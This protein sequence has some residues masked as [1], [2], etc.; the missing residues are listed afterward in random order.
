MNRKI[1]LVDDE[2]E[3]LDSFKRQ[4]RKL[5][6]IDT[7][8][9]GLNGLRRVLSSEPFAVIVSDYHMPGID[10]IQF[11]ASVKQKFPD[12]VRIMLTGKAELQTA[13]DAVN[14]GH[15][16]RF[17][18]KPCP[19][20]MLIQTLQAGLEQYRLITA[21][22]DLLE[23]TLS[24][25]IK[26]LTEILS[27][28]N[29]SAFGRAMR[30]KSYVVHMVDRLKIPEAWQYEIAALLSFIGCVT[31]PPDVMDK[32][33]TGARLSPVEADLAD[34]HPAVAKELLVN[35]PR[36]GS[37]ARMIEA[38]GDS[39]VRH[40]KNEDF[41]GEDLISLGGNL[42]AIAMDFDKLI[43]AGKSKQDALGDLIMHPDKYFQ[44]A[45]TTLKDYEVSPAD[46]IKRSIR[47]KDLNTSMILNEDIS[48][49][50]G[51]LIAVKGQEVSQTMLRRLRAFAGSV[52]INEPFGIVEKRMKVG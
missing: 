48:A 23:K 20:E 26:V 27:L 3:I 39:F 52:G 13:I 38:Q 9:G 15:I 43:A 31:I 50:N 19:E 45:V 21:E 28:V 12:S 49:S 22:R 7:A 40:T 10:G 11:L 14:E 18:T 47:A 4:L 32:I 30:I 51:M 8:N 33:N 34:K 44:D 1:L 36:L 41:Q 5:F 29:P 37:V 24:G 25:S 2:Q 17:L 46:Q 6:D 35:I 42:L 16:F